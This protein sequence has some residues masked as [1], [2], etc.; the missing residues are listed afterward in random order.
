MTKFTFLSDQPSSKDDFNRRTFAQALSHALCLPKDAPGLIVGIEGEWG[1][2]KSTVIGFIKEELLKHAPAPILLDFNPWM[3]SGSSA[4]VEIFINQLAASVGG[5]SLS[6]QTGKGIIA[7]RKL[8]D[9]AKLLK[10][11]KHLKY[12]KYVPALG[13]AGNIAGDVGE[14]AGALEKPIDEANNTAEAALNDLEKLLPKLDLQAQKK[15]V[16]EAISDLDRS[17]VVI[18]DDLDRLPPEEIRSMVQ[19]LKAVADFPRVT[20]LLAYDPSIIGHAL[21]LQQ[22]ETKGRAYLE[23]IVQISYPLP[24]AFPWQQYNYAVKVIYEL[25]DRL[26]I[27]RKPFEEE[28]FSEAISIVVKLSKQPRDVVRLVNRLTL[29]LPA[30]RDEI[31]LCDVIVFEMLTQKTPQLRLAI[32]RNPEDFIGQNFGDSDV[33][34]HFETDW[35]KFV[36]DREIDK[37]THWKRHLPSDQ[38]GDENITRACR[39]L[40]PHIGQGSTLKLN[41]HLRIAVTDR[42]MRLFALAT[43]ERTPSLAELDKLLQVPARLQAMFENDPENY[44]IFLKWL[45]QYVGAFQL[46]DIDE[47]INT[48]IGIYRHQINASTVSDGIPE[49]YENLILGLIRLTE[50]NRWPDLIRRLIDAAPLSLSE[51][52]VLVA[53]IQHGKWSVDP[54]RSVPEEWQLISDASIADGLIVM[55][56]EKVQRITSEQGIVNEPRLHSVLYRWLQLGKEPRAVLTAVEEM[57]SSPP[58]LKSF[59]RKYKNDSFRLSVGDFELVWDAGKLA[60]LIEANDEM[61][62]CYSEYLN[63]LRSN[64]VL[65]YLVE[66]DAKLTKPI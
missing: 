32:L 27:T 35:S 7:G 13:L 10:H 48:L 11:F 44:P 26:S 61:R 28:R 39:F 45:A 65:S 14:F 6:S 19:A 63:Q 31:N 18:V 60:T 16:I 53:A 46:Q 12:L 29:S 2:G 59:L 40:F 24:P 57:C 4:L 51:R 62:E 33:Y 66:R 20:Y 41:E 3:V 50:K 58:G 49:A 5:D 21:D 34:S 15:H 17:I 30:T 43:M 37:T 23:K 42:L 56:C 25:L 8:L 64:A 55:W 1:S 22:N 47:P 54:H 9:Y 38:R 36:D 52:F